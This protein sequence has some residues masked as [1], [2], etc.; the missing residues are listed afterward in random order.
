MIGNQVQQEQKPGIG[1]KN[2]GNDSWHDEPLID[3]Q[4]QR[5]I[6]ENV[7]EKIGQ[8]INTQRSLVKDNSQHASQMIP[9]SHQNLANFEPT[10]D[11]E[12]VTQTTKKLGSQK[13]SQKYSQKTATLQQKFNTQQLNQQAQDGH[14]DYGDEL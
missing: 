9:I 3:Q 12:V 6:V 14:V 2:N 5:S 8:K 11:K 4:E 7:I 13:F 1:A 10:Q